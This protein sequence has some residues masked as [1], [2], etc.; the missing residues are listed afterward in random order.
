MKKI[1]YCFGMICFLFL[2]VELRAQSDAAFV[3][4]RG[5]ANTATGAFKAYQRFVDNDSVHW[6]LGGDAT[7]AFTATSLANWAAGG[8]DQIGMRS[9]IN[10]FAN[11]KKGKRTFENYACNWKNV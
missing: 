4:A 2:N 1:I 10:L 11:Y 7:L 9:A 8:E 3:Q 6:L 5:T